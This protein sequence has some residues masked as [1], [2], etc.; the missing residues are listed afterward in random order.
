MPIVNWDAEPM[1][2][3]FHRIERTG[4]YDLSLLYKRMRGWFEENNYLYTEKENTTLVKDKG[5]EQKLRMIGER[6]VTDYFK[7]VV[8]V[9]FLIVE[10]QKVKVKNK[11]LDQGILGA[12]ITSQLHFDYRHIWAKNKFSKLLRFIYNNFIIRN[13]ILDVYSPALKFETD[14]LCNV[15]KEV[16]DM[17]NQ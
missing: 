13:K 17:Y 15:M 2:I 12:F 6:K 14:D 16:M 9:K 3:M 8:D 1:K 5:V 7:F 4:I 10:M 11:D